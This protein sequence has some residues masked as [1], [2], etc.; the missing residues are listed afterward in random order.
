VDPADRKYDPA[1]LVVNAVPDPIT[2]TLPVVDTVPVEY[3]AVV[4]NTLSRF[5][6]AQE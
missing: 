6:R 5:R 4:L 3:G 1:M 2:V